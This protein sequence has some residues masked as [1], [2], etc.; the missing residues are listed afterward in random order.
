MV[1]RLM[2]GSSTRITLK[3]KCPKC[4]EDIPIGFSKND[5]K[6]AIKM[7]KRGNNKDVSDRTRGQG[8]KPIS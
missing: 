4:G 7:I 5:L 1:H 6:N 8:V 3:I 2:K